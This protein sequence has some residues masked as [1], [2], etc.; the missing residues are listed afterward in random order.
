MCNNEAR[1]KVL[2]MLTVADVVVSRIY[3]PEFSELIKVSEVQEICLPRVSPT[4]S[5]ASVEPL[6]EAISLQH[7]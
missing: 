2:K 7:R 4:S 3:Y 6:V 1:G 5:C